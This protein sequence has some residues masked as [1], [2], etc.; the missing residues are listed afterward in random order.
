MK[1]VFCKD[2]WSG[3]Y[4]NYRRTGILLVLFVF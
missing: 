4:F 2:K 1:N 3:D